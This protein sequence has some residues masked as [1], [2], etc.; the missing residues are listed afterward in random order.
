MDTCANTDTVTQVS[1]AF[2]R[3]NQATSVEEVGEH[4]HAMVIRLEQWEGWNVLNNAIERSLEVV[5]SMCAETELWHTHALGAHSGHSLGMII[6]LIT[7]TR[8]R[9]QESTHLRSLRLPM[10]LFGSTEYER[11]PRAKI[12]LKLCPATNRLR[13]RNAICDGLACDGAGA[14]GLSHTRL[15]LWVCGCG[16]GRGRASITCMCEQRVQCKEMARGVGVPHAAAPMQV[17]LGVV[18]AQAHKPDK[19]AAASS[20]RAQKTHQKNIDSHKMQGRCCPTAGYITSCMRMHV[21]IRCTC[22]GMREMAGQLFTAL[23]WGA[24]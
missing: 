16:C 6:C 23:R 2:G 4:G 1:R 19:P 20:L 8:L 21:C 14:V 11:A 15:N 24:N 22:H 9:C 18:W 12:G 5:G 13:E 3:D 7:H 10:M 17:S